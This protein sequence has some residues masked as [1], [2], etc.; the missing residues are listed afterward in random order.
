MS[1]RHIVRRGTDAAWS[2]P[3]SLE[4][5]TVGY[6]RWTVVDEAAGAVNTGFGIGEFAPGG[7]IHWHVHSYEETLFLLEGEVALHTSDSSAL[8]R[9]G[10]YALMVIGLPHA[11]ANAGEGIAR[12]AA[13]SA[14]QP[15]PDHDGDTYFVLALPERDPVPVDVRDGRLHHLAPGPLP[16]RARPER[17]AAQGSSRIPRRPGRVREV[18]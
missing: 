17:D 15:R 13:M 14:P 10:D 4:G 2:L 1:P 3:P 5:H 16:S 9:P 12:L 7:R 6:R 11:L 18:P 8:L